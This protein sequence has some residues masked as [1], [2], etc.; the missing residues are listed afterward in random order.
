M[1]PEVVIM[2]EMIEM[3]ETRIGTHMFMFF[4]SSVQGQVHRDTNSAHDLRR[5]FFL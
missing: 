5:K 1:W 4:L 3:A 2:Q